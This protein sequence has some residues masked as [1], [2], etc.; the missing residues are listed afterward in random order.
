MYI[1]FYYI[2]TQRVYYICSFMT[3]LHILALCILA[4]LWSYTSLRLMWFVHDDVIKWRHFPCYWPFVRGIHRSQVNSQHKGQWRGALM[5]SLICARINGWVNN[6][7]AGDLRRHRVHYDVILMLSKRP[8][9]KLTLFNFIS[10]Y[11]ELL[12]RWTQTMKDLDRI[13]SEITL[14]S[15]VFIILSLRPTCFGF[16]GKGVGWMG[17][18]FNSPRNRLIQD[19]FNCSIIRVLHEPS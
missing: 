1:V 7:E 3:S 11:A 19:Y 4:L 9:I 8:E 12:T 16:K 2:F 5:F 10:Y 14:D 18:G 6:G 15:Y 13:L 17:P